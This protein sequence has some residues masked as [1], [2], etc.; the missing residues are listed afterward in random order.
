MTQ[1]G[2][3]TTTDYS[4]DAAG[5]RISQSVGGLVTSYLVDGANP[6]G[7]SQT[8]EETQRTANGAV[9]KATS[10]IL[11]L[12]VVGQ[13]VQSAGGPISRMY[14]SY[15]GHGSTRLLLQQDGQIVAGQVYSYDAY[16]LALGFEPSTALTS[17]L[18]SG[19]QTDAT[20]LQDLRARYYDA[21][22]GRFAKLTRP[23]WPAASLQ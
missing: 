17:L 20:G 15:D 1:G 3:T 4:Y 14:L 6:T 22:P 13:A 11:G 19:E 12:D 18:F 7:Y 10:Y 9:Q 2:T 21:R 16:G 5:Q 23:S 8:L